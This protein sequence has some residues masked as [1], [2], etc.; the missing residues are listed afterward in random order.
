MFF[1]I[2]E[3]TIGG[4]RWADLYLRFWHLIFG[5]ILFVFGISIRV[6]LVLGARFGF[7]QSSSRGADWFSGAEPW[8]SSITILAGSILLILYVFTALRRWFIRR[9]GERVLATITAV[10]INDKVSINNV[11]PVR[12]IAS[13]MAGGILREFRSQPFGF[14]PTEYLKSQDINTLPVYVYRQ[15]P[16]VY[17]MD[18]SFLTW[19]DS[20][21]LILAL[22]FWSVAMILSVAIPVFLI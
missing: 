22:L 15:N 13:G 20:F 11:Y 18:T 7:T 2:S 4:K 9:N 10:E 1:S 19:R 16:S 3:G 6:I 21:T 14:D 17:V 5:S 8:L 12:I